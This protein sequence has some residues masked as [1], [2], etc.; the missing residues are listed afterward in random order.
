MSR[1]VVCRTAVLLRCCEEVGR[2]LW[3]GHEEYSHESLESEGDELKWVFEML[4]KD[5]LMSQRQP[6]Y[7]CNSSISSKNF[8]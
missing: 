2:V 1:I 4:N 5:G 7:P 3:G 6:N 8:Y